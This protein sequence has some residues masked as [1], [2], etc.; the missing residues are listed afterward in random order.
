[1]MQLC[2][3][4]RPFTPHGSAQSSVNVVQIVYTFHLLSRCPAAAPAFCGAYSQAIKSG[5]QAAANKAANDAAKAAAEAADKVL[6][7]GGSPAA[8]AEA[9]KNAVKGGQVGTGT[10]SDNSAAASSQA[11]IGHIVRQSHSMST[12][13]DQGCV[14]HATTAIRHHTALCW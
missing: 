8:A 2:H 12:M 7:S 4:G 5:D 3:S 11:Q 1:M 13:L 9:A 6:K 14:W 10:S